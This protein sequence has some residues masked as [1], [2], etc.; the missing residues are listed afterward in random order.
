MHYDVIIVGSGAAGL[1]AALYAQRYALKALVAGKEFGGETATAGT[2]ENWPGS[3]EIDGYELVKNM[4][5]HA[6]SV[7]AEVREGMVSRIEKDKNCFNVFFEDGKEEHSRAV[8]LA[9]GAR[10]RRLNLPR[11]KEFTG[12]GVHYCVTC[13][14]PLFTGKTVAMVGGGDSSV[15]GINFL[16]EYAEK[17][18]FIFRTEEPRAEPMN[19]RRLEDLGDKVVYIPENEVTELQGENMLEKVVLARPHEGSKELQVHGLFV[20]IGFDPD[21]TFAEQLGLELDK[22]GYLKTDNMMRTN[23]EGV[24]AAGDATNHFGSFKQDITA[25][26]LGT[27]AATAAADYVKGSQGACEHYNKKS[28]QGE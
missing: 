18:Y 17:I 21:K 23:V 1:A 25:S 13:D 12:K 2:I 5:E 22:S 15:K 28:P 8:I 6:E 3:K 14:G 11:E 9:I 10:R 20:E 19:M 16:G 7:G 27:V 24:Y 4:K 26:A